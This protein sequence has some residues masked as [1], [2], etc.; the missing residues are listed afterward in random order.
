MPF[1]DG[2]WINP[3][4]EDV[5]KFNRSLQEGGSTAQIPVEVQNQIGE[6]VAVTLQGARNLSNANSIISKSLE[7]IVEKGIQKVDVV[8]PVYNGLH[9]LRPCLDSVVKRTTW[10]Y[11]IILVDDG[12][13]EKTKQFLHEFTLKTPNVTLITNPKNIGFAA[14]V[15]RGIKGGSNPYI[16][17]LNSDTIVTENWLTKMIMALE[18]DEK[19]KLVNPVTNNTAMIDV[20]MQ[21]GA[22]YLDMNYALS[23]T[24]PH[25][26]SEIVP[27]GFCFM[28]ERSLLQDVGYFDE[29]YEGGYGEE[30]DF[31]MKVITKV[32]DGTFQRW[33]SV[34]ADNSYIF[35]ERG[36][37]FS[38][39]GDSK[40]MG[41]R[42]LGSTRFHSIWPGFKPWLKSLDI[43]KIMAP[44]RSQLPPRALSRPDARYSIA[45]V[46]HSAAFCGG[47]ANIANIVNELNERNINAKVVLVKRKPDKNTFV[48]P[49]LRSAPIVYNSPE[50]FVKDFGKNI[51]T[52]G[53]VVAATNELVP[54]V[55]QVCKNNTNLRSLLFSQSYDPE[56]AP[57][58]DVKKAMVE[59]YSKLE[60]VITCSK[61]LSAKIEKAHNVKT[62]GYV[63]P[64]VNTDLFYPRDRS[65]GDPRPTVL[66]PFFGN[67]F[68]GH[69]RGADT[70]RHLNELAE[71]DGTDLRI[72]AY[73]TK[74]VADHPFITGLGQLSQPRLAQ[75][76][77][78]EV[79]IFVNI[80]HVE[81]YGMPA[82]EALACGVPVV[83][84]QN[85]GITEYANEGTIIVDAFENPANTAKITYNLLVGKE[86]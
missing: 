64:G 86:V 47:M 15:N 27:T 23:L 84:F 62:I 68:K 29:G 74:A 60:K 57:S 73:G 4:Q 18:A 56:I 17:L 42:Q 52:K 77:G 61:W 66:I 83:S 21:E 37:S 54:I 82:L 7:K 5:D 48:L 53:I 72:L 70:A 2:I 55:E 76:L 9:V 69:K 41:Y 44:I 65:K 34:L 26:H 25:R 59:N 31:F 39:L 11:Q 80:S 81:S 24:S 14:S 75:I 19:N 45:F 20:P 67:A 16:C 58:E 13:D 6:L 50:E 46:V 12:S 1:K 40:H 79:D 71:K 78:T 3:T 38:T 36:S 32:K 30:T 43:E 33:R 63:R 49:E 85:R 22:S 8:V 28:F 51:F 10:P 35:H